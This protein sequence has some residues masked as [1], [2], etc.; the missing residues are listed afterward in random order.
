MCE[1]YAIFK[2]MYVRASMRSHTR[3]CLHVFVTLIFTFIPELTGIAVVVVVVL[4]VE[5]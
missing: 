2:S 1:C 3:V 4:P 5:R